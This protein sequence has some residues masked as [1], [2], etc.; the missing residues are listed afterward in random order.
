[1]LIKYI[2]I[3]WNL[4]YQHTSTYIQHSKKDLISFSEVAKNYLAM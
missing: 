4:Y 2:M 1:M 3:T